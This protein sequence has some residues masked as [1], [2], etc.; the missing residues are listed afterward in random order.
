MKPLNSK[1]LNSH[2]Y[3]HRWFSLFCNIFLLGFFFFSLLASSG[4]KKIN[5]NKLKGVWVS[6]TPGDVTSKDYEEWTFYKG[7]NLK[8]KEI[9]YRDDVANTVEYTGK[10]TMKSRKSFEVSDFPEHFQHYDAKWDI[11]K[12]DKSKLLIVSDY[13]QGT[14]LYFKEFKK[15]DE[16]PVQ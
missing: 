1:K 14:G 3:I 2:S 5:E 6:R 11:A 8:I 7:G 9:T 15:K 13:G 4:C 16:A 10:Y 12:L